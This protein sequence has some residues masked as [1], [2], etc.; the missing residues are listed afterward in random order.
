[1][2]GFPVVYLLFRL[3]IELI[4][5]FSMYL[6][7]GLRHARTDSRDLGCL[8]EENP[9]TS[10]LWGSYILGGDK[11]QRGQTK[12]LEY[13]KVKTHIRKKSRAEWG[14]SDV[15]AEETVGRVDLCKSDLWMNI[16]RESIPLG[17]KDSCKSPKTRVWLAHSRNSKEDFPGAPVVKSLS[18]GG[19]G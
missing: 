14:K 18:A 12:C 15:P 6:F 5:S 7:R 9:K 13:Y 17:A 10:C 2:P 11:K 19:T 8:S 16:W 3:N 4:H 1:M